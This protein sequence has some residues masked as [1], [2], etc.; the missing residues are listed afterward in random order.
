ME[1]GTDVR[2]H[3]RELA[4]KWQEKVEYQ[5]VVGLLQLRG[6][7]E[8]GIR[9]EGEEGKAEKGGEGGGR[10]RWRWRKGVIGGGEGRKP[11]PR[12]VRARARERERVR[13]EMKEKWGRRSGGKRVGEGEEG[14][15]GRRE[16]GRETGE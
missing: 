1:A 5:K 3:A 9:R 15:S 7:R 14:V 10:G 6:E 12:E 11:L 13:G 2:D 8:E 4:A 16:R